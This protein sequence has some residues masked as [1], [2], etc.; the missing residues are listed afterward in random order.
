[1]K[2]K[3]IGI[4]SFLMMALL[5]VGLV[6]AYGFG[7]GLN[8]PNEEEHEA[9]VTAIE[10]QDYSAWKSLMEEQVERMR[11]SITEDNFNEM[12]ARHQERVEQGFGND[13]RKLDGSGRGMGKGLGRGPAE[14][15]S[16]N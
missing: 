3:T 1:M 9:M 5:T 7:E 6:S 14:C 12:I 4:A 10:N 2:K 11:S 8:K 16:T 15:L 13:E